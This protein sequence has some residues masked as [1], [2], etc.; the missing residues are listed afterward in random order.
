MR[1]GLQR[2]CA[3]LLVGPHRLNSLGRQR[4]NNFQRCGWTHSLHL[5]RTRLSSSQCCD[6]NVTTGL[7]WDEADF[8]FASR[9]PNN[10]KAW[11]RKK[12]FAR[13]HSSSPHTTRRYVL[14]TTVFLSP[15]NTKETYL[16][17]Q[18][19]RRLG[20]ARKDIFS[21]PPKTLWV[22]ETPRWSRHLS[23][24]QPQVTQNCY[25]AAK[26]TRCPDRG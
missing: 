4:P 11:P 18:T 10:K 7:A 19:T 12:T 20:R 23:H 15:N 25:H 21:S 8:T 22:N 16:S 17:P 24:A 9:S 1:Q 26:K 2:R 14:H 6:S 5:W 3:K 13:R